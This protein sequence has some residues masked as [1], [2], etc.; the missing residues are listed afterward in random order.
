MSVVDDR[1]Y[2]IREVEHCWIPMADGTRLS[3]RLWLPVVPD[4]G[5]VPAILEYIPYRKRDLVRRRDERNHLFF[6]RHGYACLRVDMRGSGDSEGVMTDMYSADELDDALQVI[7][8][9]A[10]QVWCDGKVGMMGTSWG[11]TAS[12]QAAAR[13]PPALR[14]IIAVC[15]TD[16][17]F[18]DDIHHMGGCVLTDTVEWGATLPAI[19]ALPP[20]PETVGPAWRSIWQRRLEAAAFPLEAWIRHETRDAYWRWGSVCEEPDAIACPLLA[21]GG[22]VDRYSNTVMNLLGCCGDQAWGIVGPWGHHYPDQASPGPGIGFQQEALRWW[23]RWLKGVENGIEQEARL[24]V[25]MQDYQPPQRTIDTRR[26]RWVAEAQW[27]STEIV[28]ERFWLDQGRLRRTPGTSGQTVVV[29]PTLAVGI[30]SGDTGYFGRSCGLPGDQ[31]PDDANALVFESDPLDAPIEILGSV[32]LSVSLS[33]DQ[34]LSSLVVRLNDL[35][36]DGTSARVAFAV[37]NLGLEKDGS[38]VGPVV[39]DKARRY[40]IRLPNTAYRFGPDHRLRLA[41][42]SSYWPMVWPGPAVAAITVHLDEAR[43][44]LPVRAK[45]GPEPEVSLA[46]P[47]LREQQ[48]AGPTRLSRCLKDD[49]QL[50]RRITQW[51]QPLE[52]SHFSELG[53]DLSLESRATQEIDLAEPR[54]ASASFEQRYMLERDDWRVEIRSHAALT[55]TAIT[56]RPTGFL[57]VREDGALIFFRRWSPVIPRCHS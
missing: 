42:S 48:R 34:P 30:A 27:P 38:E 4:G 18:N 40:E 37:R 11:G 2:D 14:A 52:R 17:R 25:W 57:E 9:I 21:I 20:D 26:G 33:S 51:H 56:F 1:L 7:A 15:A 16:D 54:S 6:A 49:T 13:Q 47:P 10:R 8:W 53:L 23:D 43:L 39:A 24:R 22:W 12:L 31:R 45:A 46:H 29:P 36:P 50:G 3:A 5:A 35:A 32:V 55:C 41:L 44:S 28:D 19:S